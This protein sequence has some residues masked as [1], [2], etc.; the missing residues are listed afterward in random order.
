MYALLF[1]LMPGSPFLHEMSDWDQIRGWNVS[2]N[3]DEASGLNQSIQ[4][5]VRNPE[6]QQDLDPLWMW[7]RS[8]EKPWGKWG[9]HC[10]IGRWWPGFLVM[11]MGASGNGEWMKYQH[12]VTFL[13]SVI[14]GASIS[15][16]IVES[17]VQRRICQKSAWYILSLNFFITIFWLKD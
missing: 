17:G 8:C 11:D 13:G 14:F 16:R 12:L 4:C 1:K 7:N 15:V 2:W 3:G 6:G 10:F 9:E 5:D